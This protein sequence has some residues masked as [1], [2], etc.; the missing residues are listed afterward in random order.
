MKR[1]VILTIDDAPSAN[2]KAKVDL[3]IEHDISAVFFCIGNKIEQYKSDLIY[4][5]KQ[6]FIL[7]NHSYTHPWFSSINKQEGIVEIRKTDELLND[8]YTSAGIHQEDRKRFFRFPYGD[9]GN[10]KYGYHQNN[11]A[12]AKQ[13]HFTNLI[14][15]KAYSFKKI[16]WLLWHDLASNK[17]NKYEDFQ[18]YLIELGYHNS[19]QIDTYHNDRRQSRLPIDW[20]WDFDTR[21]WS[22]N[23]NHWPTSA[24]DDLQLKL[25]N[26]IQ[27]H[28]SNSNNNIIQPKNEIMLCH[29][30]EYN[31]DFIKTLVV[32][33]KNL[34]V[35]FISI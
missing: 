24:D 29:D 20:R 23:S 13:K 34:D 1:N 2:F 35:G 25:V 31:Y 5:I 7:G 16:T 4:A 19:K 15:N 11:K 14:K 30:Y 21:D 3:L 9:A 10:G 22:L 17:G 18:S 28:F 27:H 26:R 32:R 8:I 12:A 6:G 33:L